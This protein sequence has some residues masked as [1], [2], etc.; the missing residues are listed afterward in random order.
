[1]DIFDNELE[2]IEFFRETETRETL[3]LPEND[4]NAE[5]VY[6]SKSGKSGQTVL[7]NL[8]LRQIFLAMNLVI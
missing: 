3:L 7:E 2:I 1:M 5:Q 4:E 8:I 6:L